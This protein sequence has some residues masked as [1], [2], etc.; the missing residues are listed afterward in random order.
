LCGLPRRI[1]WRKFS[2]LVGDQVDAAL[3]PRCIHVYYREKASSGLTLGRSSS[4][5]HGLRLPDDPRLLAVLEK[6]RTAIEGYE[7][8]HAIR[9]D[10]VRCVAKGDSRNASSSIPSSASL[11]SSK[12]ALTPSLL[13][14]RYLQQNRLNYFLMRF[15]RSNS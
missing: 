7:A 11:R 13:G 9:K 4:G 15:E 2:R 14:S 12:P 10:Q 1:H 5:T 3:H 6:T 8:M